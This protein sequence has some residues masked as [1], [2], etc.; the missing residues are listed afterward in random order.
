MP[1]NKHMNKKL[2]NNLIVLSLFTLLG[3]YFAQTP[4]FADCES[5]YGGGEKCEVN[6]R[7]EIEKKVRIEDSDDDDWEDKVMD[8]ESDEVVEF[9]IKVTN[10]SDDEADSADDMRIED[11]LPDEMERVGGSG[12]TEYWDD[13]EPGETKTFYIRAKISEDEYDS[14]KDF[15]KCVVNKVELEWDGDF[16]GSDTAT[17]CF[18]NEDVKKLPDTGTTDVFA[19]TGAI[20]LLAGMIL[21]IK[22]KITA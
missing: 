4:V 3:M 8:V 2:I 18:G 9:K 13:F 5:T 6:K 17:V 12:L 1:T 14:D 22:N 11:N 7:F 21:R 15:E 19:I 16:Q 20:S 10:N